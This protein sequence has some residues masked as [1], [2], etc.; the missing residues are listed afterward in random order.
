[1]EFEIEKT[2][3]EAAKIYKPWLS[4][5]IGTV[6]YLKS[7]IKRRCPM[8]IVLLLWESPEVDYRCSWL[9]SQKVE[10]LSCFHDLTLI[11]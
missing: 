1:M 9:N 10:E 8:T 2:D 7:D 4:Y 11:I 6:V 3:L 5:K